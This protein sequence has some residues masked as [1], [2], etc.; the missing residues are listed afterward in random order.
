MLC[1]YPS[2][3]YPSGIQYS[4]DIVR[5]STYVESKRAEHGREDE[6]SGKGEA[7]RVFT[8]HKELPRYQTGRVVAEKLK[9]VSVDV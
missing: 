7:T 5:L 9:S 3:F 8:A 6:Y 1:C 2:L 4:N